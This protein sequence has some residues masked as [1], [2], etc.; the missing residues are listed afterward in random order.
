[1]R[2]DRDDAQARRRRAAE[3]EILLAG[4]ELALPHERREGTR[5]Q[6]C[7]A[8]GG[9]GD[10]EHERL[11]GAGH[12]DVEKAYLLGILGRLTF[13]LQFLDHIGER[14]L[15]DAALGVVRV[16]ADARRRCERAEHPPVLE[17]AREDARGH[18]RVAPAL[19][20][21]DDRELEAL[22]RVDR[23][24]AHGVA[25]AAREHGRV[26][27]GDLEPQVELL[28]R[29]RRAETQFAREI[30]QVAHGSKKVR[31][32]GGALGAAALEPQQPAGLDERGLDDVGE[33]P[34]PEPRE[35]AREHL[36]RAAKAR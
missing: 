10:R 23:H 27:L 25:L 22:R 36:V 11:P 34:A 35:G 8:L 6:P 26:G 17:L 2:L 18:A 33:A 9:L 13:F 29:A 32:L 1:M 4:P 24:D 28:A 14:R 30:A 7:G 19:R 16:V 31:G 5:S 3:L 21:G 12:A 20:H 15:A